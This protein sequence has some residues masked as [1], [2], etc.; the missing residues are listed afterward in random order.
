MSTPAGA[1]RCRLHIA[2]RHNVVNALAAAA[3]AL[4]AGAPLD[5]VVQGLEAFVP[6]KGRSRALQI[7]HGGRG[8]TVVD[9]SYNANP[10]SMRAAIDVLADLPA[11]QLLVMG[12]MGEVGNQG[13]AF[14]AEAGEHARSAGISHVYTLGAL[15]A[16]AAAACGPAAQH[17][18]DMASLQAAV[19]K[20]LPQVGSVLV[21][22]SRF[23]KMEQVVEAMVATAQEQQLSAAA[24]AG[25]VQ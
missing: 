22:G 12:D 15:S 18:E 19:R 17:F 20:A 5:A 11:P 2:G 23:M 3:C 1:A 24:G 14:H 13:P 10:D 9:D 4:A 16:H 6:V 7:T 25:G 21:K 8:I